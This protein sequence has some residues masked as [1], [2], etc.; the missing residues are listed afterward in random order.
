VKSVAVL[1]EASLGATP[2]ETTPIVLADAGVENVNAHVD[3]LVTTGVL[4]R[5]LA[6]TELKVLQLRDRKVVAL[7]KTSMALPPL[8]EQRH[9]GPAIRRILRPG[10]QSGASTF[11]VSRT[12]A[13]TRCTSSRRTRFQ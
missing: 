2:S 7:A 10:I 13:K 4:R 1:V 9:H 11:G 5:V 6:F 3:N 8:V 12:V